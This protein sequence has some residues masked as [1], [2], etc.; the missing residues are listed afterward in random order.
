MLKRLFVLLMLTLVLLASCSEAVQDNPAADYE[1]AL[2]APESEPADDILPADTSDEP[3]DLTSETEPEYNI[4]DAPE[5]DE[6]EPEIF[7][8]HTSGYT[9]AWRV[10]P[11]LMHESIIQCNCLAFLVKTDMLL[12][13]LQGSHCH[14]I[15]VT[16]G[17]AATSRRRG[18]MISSAACSAF[19]A[20][21]LARVL[22][23]LSIRSLNLRNTC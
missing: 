4:T 17:T 1:P 19:R 12:T 16:T 5:P 3:T 7:W 22:Q 11:T 9:L 8:M 18:F 10:L 2:A 23:I 6:S 20:A 15:G 14:I 13:L 21:G